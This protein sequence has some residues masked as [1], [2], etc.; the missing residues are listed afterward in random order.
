MKAQAPIESLV[1]ASYT[2]PTDAPES[3]GTL[4]WH[5]TTLVLV[6][7][8]AG[9]RHGIGYSY[10]DRA[11]A[12]LIAEL[13]APLLQGRDAFAINARWNDMRMAV[14]NLG[15]PGIASMA[16]SAVDNALWDVKAK[17][18]NLPL[19]TLLG[20]A[21]SS[22]EIYGSGGFTSYSVATL[23]QQL[24]G[25]AEQGITKVKMKVGRAP[26]QDLARVKAARDSIGAGTELFVDANGAYSRKQALRFAEEFSQ[27]GVSWF[28]EPVS[29]D[30][31]DGLHLLRNRAP[32]GM[33]ISAG[34]YG[35]EL[36]YF[37]NMLSAQA[38]DVLQADAT[39]CGGV[40]GF[41]GAAALCE[42]FNLPLSSHCAPALHLPLCCAARAAIHLEYFHDHV[43][44]EQVL[45]DGASI[46]HEGA[47]SP[48]ADRNGFGLVF[49]ERDAQCYLN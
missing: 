21:R 45:F 28:E 39:R 32:A 8:E 24:G 19:A 30:D 4:Q 1:V 33:A 42:A 3:D 5:S 18:L 46:P 34:E 20:M 7:I 41:L 14:R 38:V 23:Q 27:C 44:I 36:R 16:I 12:Q 47:L 17:C 11:T 40:T 29:S 31:L 37:K 10:A 6:Q 9:G 35:Y 26:G 43:R 48:A 49:K 15:H 2:V 13:F 25:W 22:I